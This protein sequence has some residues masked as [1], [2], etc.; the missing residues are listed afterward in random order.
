MLVLERADVVVWLD[1]PPRVWLPRLLRRTVGRIVRRETLWNGNRETF[2]RAFLSRE[3]LILFAVRSYPRIRR[4][5]EERLAP[6]PV[7][8]LRSP[9]AVA[10]WLEEVA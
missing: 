2:R 6:F 5:N 9:S 4:R 8:R 1:L 3:S 7:V 10:R